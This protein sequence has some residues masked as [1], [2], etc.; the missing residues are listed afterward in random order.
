M[1]IAFYDTKDYDKIWFEKYL[2]EFGYEVSFFESR[3]NEKTA[4]LAAGYDAVCLFVNDDLNKEA[5]DVLYKNGV[6]VVLMRCAGYDKVDLKA[7]E[8]KLTVLRVPSYSPTAVAEYT[9]AMALSI[10]RKTHRAY[11]RTR[12]FNFKI[13]NLMGTTIKGKRIGIIGT[14]KIGK[15]AARIFGGVGMEVVGYDMY[16]DEKS[17]IKYVSLDELFE[18]SDIISLHCPLTKESR[19]IINKDSIAKMKN[20]AI[21]VNTSRGA[22]IDT[23]ALIDALLNKKFRGVAL[24]VY[25]EE[26]EYFFEDKSDEIIDDE[27]LIRLM[28][29]PN[30]LV[31]SH[32]AFFTDES[33]Q[34]IAQTTLNNLRAYE[35]G[36]TLENEVKHK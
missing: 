7:C 16:P 35:N 33:L 34:A 6:K 3:L 27:E 30:V 8:G 4:V 5:V 36:L 25:E 31:T 20:D 23:K 24:D 15:E 28:S 21:L 10:N 12:D 29:F 18:T 13:N 1:K 22:L 14:G 26:D 11:V 32:Q 2:P 9:L 19:H 17:G